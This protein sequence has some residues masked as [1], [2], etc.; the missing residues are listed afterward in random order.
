M[1]FNG[2]FTIEEVTTEEV[3]LALSDPEMIKH[4]LPGCRFLV[5]V[6]DAN[7]VDFDALAATKPEEESPILPEADPEAVTDRSFDEGTTYGA[8]IEI[9]VGSIKPSFESLVTIDEREFPTMVASGEGTDSSN[10]FTMHSGM[11]LSENDDGSVTVEW[12]A[13]AEVF[14][15]LAQMGQRVLNPVTNRV[16]TRFF[17]HLEDQLNEVTEQQTIRSRIRDIV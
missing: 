6:E 16:V 7:D 8:L 9:G 11:D 17:T 1:E 15:R 14:G 13:S 10:S 3:W 5:E 4:C 12:W 2:T